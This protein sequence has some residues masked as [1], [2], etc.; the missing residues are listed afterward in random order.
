MVVAQKI[1]RARPEWSCFVT[2]DEY[3]EWCKGPR[4][5]ASVD[6]EEKLEEIERFWGGDAIEAW[7]SDA[8]AV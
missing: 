5:E 6:D 2:L 4:D 7:T 8:I 1:L 3:K